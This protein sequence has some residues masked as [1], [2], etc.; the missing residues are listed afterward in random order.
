[1]RQESDFYVGRK[2]AST[3]SV[4]ASNFVILSCTTV[5]S[6]V[7]E[8]GKQQTQN[9]NKTRA[10]GS[11]HSE[12]RGWR[13]HTWELESMNRILSSMSLSSFFIR[14]LLRTSWV[15]MLARSGLSVATVVPSSCSSSPSGVTRKFNR[16]TYN[17]RVRSQSHLRKLL[18]VTCNS[19][20]R[21]GCTLETGQ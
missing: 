14:A 11:K 6:E 10:T 8:G 18:Q 17:A 20:Q 21:N 15:F 19:K 13:K 16:D 7:K 1:M 3:F 5:T 2:H 12:E 4:A 9:T